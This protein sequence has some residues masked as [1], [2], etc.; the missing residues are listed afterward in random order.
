[1]GV[2]GVTPCR[3]AKTCSHSTAAGC[4][5]YGFERLPKESQ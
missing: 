2:T 3:I 4:A 5:S 1:M